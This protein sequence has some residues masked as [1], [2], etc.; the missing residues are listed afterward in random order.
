[1]KILKHACILMIGGA[2]LVTMASPELPF[3]FDAAFGR[4]PK[5]IVPLSYDIAVVP[6]TDAL[7]LTGTESVR[8]RFRSASATIE[9]DSLNEK[10]RDVRLDGQPVKNV[11][12]SD[13]QQLTTVTL[14]APA[15]PGL[16]TLT[17]SY[18]GK[19][20][21]GPQGL[22]A[23]PYKKSGGGNA[24]MLS[25]Q[26]ENTDARRMFPCWDEPAFR[27][28]FRLTMTVPA[29]WQAVSNMPIAKRAVHGATATITFKT[30][31][32]MP[33]YLLEFSG[34]DLA[35]IDG[36]RDGVKFRVWA[37]RGQE[38][39]GREALANTE[40]ILTDY[41]E[42]FGYHY[43]LP[44]LDSIAVPG[45]F[46]GA[47]ENWGAITYN[48]SLL[49]LPPTST[50]DERQ[51]AF[52]DQAHEIAHQWYGDLVTMG[53]WDDAWLNESFAEWRAGK[54]TDLRNPTWKWWETT[55]EDKEK[56]MASDARGTAQPI[57]QPI[58]DELQADSAFDS[59]IVYSKGQ[60]VLRMLENYLGP[61]TFRD[62]IRQ[63]L[64]ARA[65]S[66]ATSGD[67]WNALSA[68]SGTDVDQIA[69]GWTEQPGF[70]LVNVAR[71]CDTAGARTIS[72]R[73]TR[74]LLRG[75]DLKASH[76]RVPLLV[77][78]GVTGTPQSVLLT[79]DGQVVVAGRCEEPLSVN[80]GAIG[81]FRSQ[82][83]DATLAIN[84]RN[85]E[86][87][88]DGDKIALLDDQWALVEAGAVP[89]ASYLNLAT[90]MG[91]NLDMRAWQQIASSLATIEFDM[92]GSPGHDAFASLARSVL[93]P[94]A[95]RLGWIAKAEE[96]PEVR[97]LRQI[98]LEDLG[99][100]GDQSVID[101]A[102][103]RFE[104]LFAGR[105]V[106]EPDSQPFILNIVSRNADSATFE[107]LRAL[108]KRAVNVIDRQRIYRALANVRDRQLAIQVAEISVSPELPPED[109]TVRVDMVTKLS[110]EHPQLSWQTFSNHA[111]TL[112]APL[113]GYAPSA[114]AELV[115]RTYWNGISLAEID[116]WLR[117]HEPADMSINVD[118]SMETAQFKLAEKAALVAAVDAYIQAGHA[119][120]Q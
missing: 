33:S 22:F 94:V 38:Q 107:Q 73:Q 67:L 71:H 23:Q 83:D 61:D 32:N 108:A 4:L 20:E 103:L 64:R 44:K 12:S 91:S 14:P 58:S 9:F 28:R 27:S 79:Q 5:N 42:Y 97:K 96:G 45:G 34:G 50:I 85:F 25:T 98:V 106:I 118:R 68:A 16:H 117:A 2:P 104:G 76:W 40:E 84:T 1:M 19:I 77:R 53:W 111:E 36:E 51:H 46:S 95:N 112:M 37:I 101:E 74:F 115:P 82:Y 52:S 7:T 80:A 100:W 15:Q 41:S 29:D 43:P 87:L 70:P 116:G 10:L 26:M 99:F 48:Q 119:Q 105:D 59:D 6:D 63:Y 90:S 11:V 24:L 62:G 113:S 78:T 81:Y 30:S 55:D 92:R 114:M 89:V 49:V 18:S 31:P 66:N 109:S 69:S 102:R 39:Y 88:P 57:H 65:Y 35:H 21:Q 110:A 54:E 47:M 3:S 17:F 75:S 120:Q 93:K 72:L 13:E 86:S 8:L 60:A 56:A